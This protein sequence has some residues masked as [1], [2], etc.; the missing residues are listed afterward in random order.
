[1]DRSRAQQALLVLTILSGASLTGCIG[2]EDDG[3]TSPIATSPAVLA[4]GMWQKVMFTANEDLSLHIPHFV[5]DPTSGLVQNG[6]IIDLAAGAMTHIQLLPPARQP[7][8]WVFTG[9]HGRVHFPVREANESWTVWVERGGA[10]HP[11]ATPG[12]TAIARTPDPDGGSL[13]VIRVADI[14]GGPVTAVLLHGVRPVDPA[15]TEGQGLAH[16]EG[17]LDGRTTY[18]WVH[19][20]TDETLDLLDPADGAKGYLDRWVGSAN[21]AYEDAIAYLEGALAGFGLRTIVHR[22]E[23]PVS[24]WT[25]NVCGYKDGDVA[26]DEWLVFGAH[27]DIAPPAA[28]TPGPSTPGYGTR[29]GAYDNTAGTSMVLT[30]ARAASELTTRRTMVFCLWSSEE[31]GLWGSDSWTQNIPSDV[32]VTNYVNLD[33]AGINWPG[34]YALSAYIGP[35]VDP[36]AIDQLEMYRLAE[37]VGAGPMDLQTQIANGWAAWEADGEA[38]MWTNE[39]EDAVAIYESPTARSD[40]QPFQENLG[41]I[42]LGFNGVVDGYPCYHRDCDRLGTM[43]SH[44]MTDGRTGEQNLVEAWDV[45]TWWSMHTFM[46][47]DEQPILNALG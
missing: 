14:T 45:I 22:G 1:M 20:W 3:S 10:A 15:L 46:H 33:M 29:T 6:T 24:P 23:S 11:D 25:V 16:S 39:Y 9:A 17:W 36:D 31:E 8:V 28:Y 47:L 40:H 44:M 7:A 38:A 27:F 26:P 43:E 4:S 41:T 12:T 19:M 21:P 2:A 34:P 13:S 30:V 35:E 18:D 37:W 42:T 5:L 32:T